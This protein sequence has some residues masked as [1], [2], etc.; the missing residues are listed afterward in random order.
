MKTERLIMDILEAF[1]L[2]GSYRAAAKHVG[3]APNT[4]KKFVLARQAGD[5]LPKRVIRAKLTDD[6][7]DKI[8]EL[9]DRSSGT[10]MAHKVHEALEGMGYTGSQR[11]TS[12]AV[13]E[14]KNTYAAAQQR[15]H[16][17]WVPA[18]GQW[19]QY[20]FGDGP[21]VAG[22]ATVLFVAWLAWSKFRFVI[23]LF[24]KQ[25]PSVIGALDACFRTLGGVPSAV[26]TDNEKTVTVDHV[27]N[28][29]VRNQRIVS[30]ARWYGTAI[31]TCVPYDP[32]TKGGVEN[33]VK[34]AK[35]DL[36]PT[37]VNLR[38]EYAS[39]AE[40]QEAC[41]QWVYDI[42]H[43]EHAAGFIP[44]ERLTQELQ[45]LHPVPAEPYELAVGQQ[46]SVPSNTPMVTYQHVQYSVPYAYMG[47]NVMVREDRVNNALVI[48]ARDGDG[49]TRHIANHQLGARGDI[50]MDD[51]HFPLTT[52]T[53][54]QQRSIMPKSAAEKQFLAIGAGAQA[55]VRAAAADGT[56]RLK[57]R[58]P[59]LT[60]LTAAWPTSQVNDALATAAAV[61]RFLVADVESILQRAPVTTTEPSNALDDHSLAQGTA[62][63]QLMGQVA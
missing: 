63:W 54:P 23:P 51:A 40:L 9:V 19:L 25:M 53:G 55:Y 6:Y 59:L 31:H 22:K 57:E 52:A 47:A 2:H 29:P 35:A 7:R 12:R 26:L 28:L 33:A 8:D 10:I 13:R 60:A 18:P 46:R 37:G 30:A 24:D 41:D 45:H 32:A 11:S 44:A 36:V 15:V 58:I 49:I 27:C 4:V 20:D 48:T 1:D 16:K 39:F 21:M 14:A 43:R 17:P 38:A 56:P 3:C 42:N 50:I 61:G 5:P 62:G 34:I